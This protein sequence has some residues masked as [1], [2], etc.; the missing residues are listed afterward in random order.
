MHITNLGG[1][2]MH[3]EKKNNYLQKGFKELKTLH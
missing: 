2:A 3:I 1:R